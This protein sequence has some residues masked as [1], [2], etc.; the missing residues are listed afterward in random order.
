[1]K[2]SHFAERGCGLQSA[3]T[4]Q[5]LSHQT[6]HIDKGKLNEKNNRFKILTKLKNILSTVMQPFDHSIQSVFI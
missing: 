6:K 2:F 5:D 3:A 4:E 1:M